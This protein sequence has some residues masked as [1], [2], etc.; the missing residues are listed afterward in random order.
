MQQVVSEQLVESGAY[1]RRERSFDGIEF[2]P[3]VT[4][5]DLKAVDRTARVFRLIDIFDR[6]KEESVKKMNKALTSAGSKRR[7]DSSTGKKGIQ[8]TTFSSIL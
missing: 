7:D 2:A 8:S 1:L 3:K 5:V 4:E 6:L